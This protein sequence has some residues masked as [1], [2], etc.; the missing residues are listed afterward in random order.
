M[1]RPPLPPWLI[2]PV[3]LPFVLRQVRRSS[4]S[5]HMNGSLRAVR[6]ARPSAAFAA[7]EVGDT[8]DRYRPSCQ[9]NPGGESR[10][11]KRPTLPPW[12]ITEN[13]TTT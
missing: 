13:S 8:G 11:T 9:S 7:I 1:G 12:T 6:I 4:G 2:A 3:L 10:R 5:T